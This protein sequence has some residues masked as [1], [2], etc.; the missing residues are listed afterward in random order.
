MQTP[1]NDS[2]FQSMSPTEEISLI[3]RIP[4]PP[5]PLENLYANNNS[6]KFKKKHDKSLKKTYS[7]MD[8]RK[9]S[10]HKSKEIP[11]QL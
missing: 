10:V 5:P 8:V 7:T 4:P 3:S 1:L 9:P 11:N 6:N 2:S